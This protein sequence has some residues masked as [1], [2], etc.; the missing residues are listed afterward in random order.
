MAW[1]LSFAAAASLNLS[2]HEGSNL[3]TE[4]DLEGRFG[5]KI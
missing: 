1:D 2:G 3:V 4:T 5:G